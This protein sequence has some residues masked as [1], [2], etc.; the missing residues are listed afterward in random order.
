VN[1]PNNKQ[2]I[3]IK[4]KKAGGHGHHG[5][6]WKIAYADMVT[7]MMAFFLVMWICGMDVKTRLGIA[8]YFSNPS[9]ASGPYK[10]SSWFVVP[11][12]G[13]PRLTQGNLEHSKD[14]G[15]E[16]ESQGVMRMDP[17]EKDN[18][19]EEV[20][21]LYAKA[22]VT[23]IERDPEFSTLKDSILVEVTDEGLRVELLEGE[24]PRFFLSGSPAWTKPG[25]RIV[26]SLGGMLGRSTH[27]I[28]FEGHTTPAPK[29]IGRST[30]WDLGADRALAVRAVF[31]E[32]GLDVNKVKRVRSEGDNQLRF[33]RPDD[34]R[35]T[36]VAILIPYARVDA[37][38][39]SPH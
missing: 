9:S 28:V 13:V 31:Q 19:D 1:T 17:A 29:V 7:A 16:P 37:K 12:G 5:G 25:R 26:E 33:A 10:P 22:L 34:P 21:Q 24:E 11:S 2:P 36:R 38:P 32:A 14:K 18:F 8:D 6:A 39:N 27:H 35:N 3:V 20:A 23:V 4:R 15:G 30:K